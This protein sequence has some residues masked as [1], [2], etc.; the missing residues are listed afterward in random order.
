[1]SI[2]NPWRE[3]RELKLQLAAHKASQTAIENELHDEIDRL[4]KECQGLY[5][6]TKVLRGEVDR[7]TEQLD[8]SVRRDPKT[9]RYLKQGV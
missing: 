7:L 1:M 6:R 4:Q 2:F 9:G 5:E 3:V 8:E